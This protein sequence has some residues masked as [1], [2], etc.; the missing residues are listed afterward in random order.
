M[1]R[2]GLKASTICVKL[3]DNW[4]VRNTL[5]LNKTVVVS[6]TVF[7]LFGETSLMKTLSHEKYTHNTV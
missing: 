7:G 3:I 6:K 5:H 2:C 1:L 4:C